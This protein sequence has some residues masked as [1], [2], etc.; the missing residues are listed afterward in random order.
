MNAEWVILT[1]IVIVIVSRF[2]S[3]L[4]KRPPEKMHLV[5]EKTGQVF[6]VI[7]K[8]QP[9]DAEKQPQNANDFDEK[10]FLIAAKEAFYKTV[11]AFA[12]SDKILLKKILSP[13]VFS[14]FEK[15]IME[16]EKQGHKMEFSLIS[17]CSSKIIRDAKNP[18]KI[19]VEFISEQ[20]NVLRDATGEVL[21]GDPMFIGKVMDTWTFEK[22]KG[23]RS[24]WIITSTKSEALNA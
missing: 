23:I 10:T 13:T 24:E 3:V 22:K 19:T 11:N 2:I 17:I 8:E 1:V 12:G 9:D 14:S 18:L 4:G 15:A 20:V 7:I 16:R 6:E 21:E 5:S